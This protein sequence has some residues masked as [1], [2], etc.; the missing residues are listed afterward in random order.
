MHMHT[1]NGMLD[2]AEQIAVIESIEVAWQP[3]LNADFSGATVPSLASA[4]DHFFERERVGV[5]GAGSATKTAET[6]TD[7]TD[8]REVDVAIHDVGDG[9][10]YGVSPQA[11]GDGH[12]GFPRGTFCGRQK[13][14]LFKRQ[15]RA[16]SCGVE[17]LT[18]FRG[19]VFRRRQ[20]TDRK[21]TRLN[22]SHT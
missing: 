1:G 14:R 7:E 10:T 19:A 15:F 13:Q 22:S 12:E 5:G 11:I 9:V 17:N 2:R 20:R 6:A 16:L 18:N 4:A 21:S 3:A 8:V